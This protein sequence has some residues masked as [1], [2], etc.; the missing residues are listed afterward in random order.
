MVDNGDVITGTAPGQLRQLNTQPGLYLGRYSP[1]RR[2]IKTEDRRSS[3]LSSWWN[4]FNSLPQQLFSTRMIWRKGLIE[5]QNWWFEKINDHWNTP[6]QTTTLPK[7]MFTQKLLFKSS[8][9]LV[10][11]SSIVCPPNQQRRPLPSVPFLSFFYGTL[12]HPLTP[13]YLRP[14]EN[15]LS[16]FSNKSGT[17][18]SCY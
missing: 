9:L 15:F 2:R 3:L 5:Y 18:C 13:I 4:W 14:Q 1:Y 12:S 6:Y 10:R 8:L 16:T 17:N 11:H 7:W